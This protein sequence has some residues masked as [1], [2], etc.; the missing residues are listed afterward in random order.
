VSATAWVVLECRGTYR[1]KT[2]TADDANSS[3]PSGDI[4]NMTSN[5]NLALEPGRWRIE[6]RVRVDCSVG[7]WTY[8]SVTVGLD[9][10]NDALSYDKLECIH[11]EHSLTTGVTN[12]HTYVASDIIDLSADTTFYLNVSQSNSAGATSNIN[13][14]NSNQDAI[15]AA[16][17][18]A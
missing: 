17:R 6:F 14:E 2:R 7:S 12:V 13:F 10:A 11:R 1:K 3:T 15:V 16:E 9:I 8:Q 18:I 5:L 4:I